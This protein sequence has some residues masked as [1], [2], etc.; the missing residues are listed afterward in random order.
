M[1]SDTDHERE[2]LDLVTNRSP[3]TVGELLKLMEE[4]L[5]IPYNEA[6]HL[7][8]ELQD[9]GKLRLV[10]SQWSSKKDFNSY[11]FSVYAYWFWIVVT[12]S[13]LTTISVFAI[14]ETAVP[15]VYI[16]NVLGIVYVVFLPGYCLIKVIYPGKEFDNLMRFV[17]SIGGSLAIV[18]VIGLILNYTLFGIKLTPLMVSLLLV[19]GI[20]ALL[21]LLREFAVKIRE[22]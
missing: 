19:N 20:L 22:G 9:Q 5:Q 18:P 4:D 13:T 10:D 3:E 17:L 16:R 7:V 15:Y 21:G 14:H 11:L 1:T 12:L 2:I 6:L 8:D